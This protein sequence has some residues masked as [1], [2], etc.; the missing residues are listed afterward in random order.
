MREDIGGI[1]DMLGDS[2]RPPVVSTFEEKIF[3]ITLSQEFLKEAERNRSWL[4]TGLDD[5]IR[6][7]RW[8]LMKVM[9]AGSL[10]PISSC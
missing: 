10:K 3:Q 1:Q 6:A 7:G 9:A 8:W 4:A 5:W 2:A